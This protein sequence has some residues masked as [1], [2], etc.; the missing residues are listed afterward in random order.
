MSVK[1]PMTVYSTSTCELLREVESG[2]KKT[3]GPGT[4]ADEE[5]GGVGDAE[6]LGRG[7]EGLGFGCERFNIFDYVDG[8][9]LGEGNA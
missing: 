2:G 8:G 4:G 1:P 6:L 7:D 3:Y 9:E 5:E